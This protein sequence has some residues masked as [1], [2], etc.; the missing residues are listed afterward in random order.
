MVLLLYS[1]FG[2]CY[3]PE[4]QCQ[5]MKN[6]P[7]LSVARAG[8]I[9][10]IVTQVS[11]DHGFNPKVYAAILMQ[12]SAY[13]LDAKGCNKHG[14][15][16]GI[17]QIHHKTAKVMG[18]DIDRLTSDLR[19]SIESG[20]EV[21]GWFFKFYSSR[22]PGRWWVRY[23]CGTRKSIDRDSCNEYYRRVKRWM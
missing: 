14:C 9:S 17:A 8:K 20:G 10:E 18:F 2:V 3:F 11:N 4:L 23:N 7:N 1:L 6:N 22:E 5:I 16:Y 12:E 15:D 19:Y 13:K 21:L